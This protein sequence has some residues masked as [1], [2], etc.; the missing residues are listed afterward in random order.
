[1]PADAQKIWDV[2]TVGDVFADIVMS[3]FATMPKLGEEVECE[4][5]QYEAG[6][7][8][9]ITAC[10][11][12]KLGCN[13]ALLAVVGKNDSDWFRHRLEDCGV[14]LSYLILHASEPTATTVSVSTKVDR[15]F[16][17]YRGANK[18]LAELLA[19][20]SFRLT[21]QQAR[22]VHLAHVI[23]PDVLI[24]LARELHAVGTTLSLDVG[25]CE[26]W[27][28]DERS[29]HALTAVDVFLPNER[30]AELMTGQSNPEAMLQA[31]ADAGLPTVAL[32]LGANGSAL[33][34]Q[35][36]YYFAAP[37]KVTVLDTTGAGDCF[38][39]G[40]LFAWLRGEDPAECLR[41]ANLCGALSTQALGGIATF[42]TF[43]QLFL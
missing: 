3:G 40:F 24:E 23:A 25:W 11:L 43:E 41:L 30:E 20:P 1:M 9:A 39:A 4:Q 12:A 28:R 22:H 19:D 10:G 18:M 42:P 35:K 16:F 6:G 33:L 15:A 26:S 13:T 38:D 17:T 29:L 32:K 27:L 36:N 21:M 5:L 2:I 7:G 31:F 14:D 37:H 34:H 8:A